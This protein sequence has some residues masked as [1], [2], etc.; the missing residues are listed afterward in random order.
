MIYYLLPSFAFLGAIS[1]YRR[2]WTPGQSY[3]WILLITL[4]TIIGAL[5]NE[6]LGKDSLTYFRMFTSGYPTEIGVRWFMDML[7]G[8][9]YQCFIAATFLIAF[10]TK[11][12]SF[13]KASPSPFLS[14]LLYFSFWF[15]SY[16]VN[17][18]RQGLALGFCSMAVMGLIENKG[19]K[20]YAFWITIG[21]C[22][23]YS[24]V[25]FIP[26]IF[27][28]YRQYNIKIMWLAFIGIFFIAAAN[29]PLK[30]LDSILGNT[31]YLI[32]R[33]GSYAADESYNNNITLSFTTAHRILIFGIITYVIPQ[34]TLPESTK[35]IFIWGAFLNLVIYLL[36]SNV[37]IV[38]TRG[39]L[40]FR[41]I[42]VFS[43]AVIPSFFK[44]RSYRLFA[45]FLILLYVIWQIHATLSIP[46]GGLLPYR[47]L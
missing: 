46:D 21:V 22:C 31:S 14:L 33:I 13:K 8:F 45:K 6:D 40:Y 41:F 39:S 18:L 17:A 4:T 44:K 10:L 9:G 7:K 29:V 27:I 12:Y 11:C 16:D 36:L 26:F 30:L 35:R 1:G 19:W 3:Y 38:A 24:M 32:S 2:K 15:L 42:E 43:L 34:T 37:E 20:H 28:C 23:H 47:I 5:R 25:V